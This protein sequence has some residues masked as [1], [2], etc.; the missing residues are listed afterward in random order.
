MG[1]ALAALL[2]FTQQTQ[3]IIQ[4]VQPS[5][6]IRAAESG[7][8]PAL[9]AILADLRKDIEVKTHI[10]IEQPNQMRI[11]EAIMAVQRKNEVL[12]RRD[13]TS[14]TALMH[15]AERGHTDMVEALLKSGAD[16][17]LATSDGLSAAKL[18]R[19]A[20]KDAV[21]ELIEKSL[22]EKPNPK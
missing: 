18:A 5:A 20:G 21:A 7:D 13:D 9:Q 6:L 11:A 8:L 3:P 16:P 17:S 19:V 10:L 22:Q 4:Q 1:I 14:R 2:L 15:S 12:N